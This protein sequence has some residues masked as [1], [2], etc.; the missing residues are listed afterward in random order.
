MGNFLKNLDPSVIS[1][2]ASGCVA[3]A[4]ILSP[5]L[6]SFF[7]DWLKWSRQRK[8]AAGDRIH[9]STEELLDYLSPYISALVR[10]GEGLNWAAYHTDLLRLYYNWEQSLW[11]HCNRSERA[12]IKRLRQVMHVIT[13]QELLVRASDLVDDI[14]TLASDVT[15]RLS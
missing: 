2:I 13:F 9:Q 12:E 7:S 8:A 1:V 14:L 15:D 3:V 6:V 10:P 11:S 4:A 5:L